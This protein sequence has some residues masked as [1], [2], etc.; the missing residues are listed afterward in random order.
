MS[1]T[2][3]QGRL[4][5]AS[6]EEDV[7]TVCRDFLGLWTP[8]EIAQLPA[9]CW[10]RR[11]LDWHDVNPFAMKLIQH[12]DIGDR[13]SAPMLHKL[14]TFF[15]KAALRLAQITAPKAEASSK[16]EESRPRSGE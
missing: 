14:S 7:V 6:N 13:I 1:A 16:Q 2:G 9:T 12:I 15:T 11:D 8:E 4:N 10:P 3:W 5:A